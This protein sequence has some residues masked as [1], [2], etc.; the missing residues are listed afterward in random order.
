MGRD[1][2]LGHAKP[3]GTGRDLT[4]RTGVPEAGS[5]GNG[6]GAALADTMAEGV[7]QQGDGE[8]QHCA[9]GLRDK[10]AQT[11]FCLTALQTLL[12]GA[13]LPAGWRGPPRAERT[14]ADP[15][16]GPTLPASLTL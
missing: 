11:G 15:I 6:R 5:S 7:P 8:A 1:G 2:R 14:L 16:V 13:A 9:H 10:G 12:P 4:Q 3:S